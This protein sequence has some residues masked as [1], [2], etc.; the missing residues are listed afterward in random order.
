VIAQADTSLYRFRK[1]LRRNP[2]A[3]LAVAAAF[4]ALLAAT[5]LST[6]QARRAARERDRA[7]AEQAQAERLLQTLVELFETAN[8]TVGEGGENVPIGEF[9][10]RAEIKVDELAGQPEVHAR[11]LHVLGEIHRTR[12]DP[13]RALGFFERAYELQREMAGELDPT[14]AAVFHSLAVAT[15]AAGDIELARQRLRQSLALQERV[16]GERSLQVAQALNDLGET[17][18]LQEGVDLLERA[19]AL[20][21]ELRPQNS[22]EVAQC[23]NDLALAL[24]SGPRR[25]EARALLEQ[26]HRIVEQRLGPRHAFAVT[27][28]ENLSSAIDEPREKERLLREVVARR[29]EIYGADSMS[30]ANA[31]GNLGVALARGGDVAGAEQALRESYDGLRRTLGEQHWRTSNAARNVAR[32][33]DLRGSYV[34]ALSFWER[35]TVH[36]GNQ[37]DRAV[38]LAQMA[39]VQARLGRFEEGLA[40]ARRSVATTSELTGEGAATAL[41][42]TRICLGKVELAAGRFEAAS[43]TF[44]LALDEYAQNAGSSPETTAEAKLGLGRALAAL[45]RSDEAQSLLEAGLTALESWPLAD[46]VELAAS[47]AALAE[48]ATATR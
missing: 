21:R 31:L 44:S 39:V 18:E 2:V 16:H 23:Q 10:S 20:T 48:M 30:V 6:W 11:M 1:L 32:V 36:P 3:S 5:V 12:G 46:P 25:Q 40:T 17:L 15:A 37:R 42:Q 47:R 22:I 8:P 19:L 24:L 9:L 41:A 4:A 35:A 14:T 26:S 28:L 33:L 27:V 13:R 7:S 38:R 43:S 29:R 45:G 34:E